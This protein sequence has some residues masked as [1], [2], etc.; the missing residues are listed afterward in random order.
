MSRNYVIPIKLPLGMFLTPDQAAT[1]GRLNISFPLMGILDPERMRE[2]LAQVLGSQGWK[3]LDG[4]WERTSPDLGLWRIDPA[5][6]TLEVDISRRLPQTVSVSPDALSHPPDPEF[7]D[8]TPQDIRPEIRRI[9]EANIAGLEEKTKDDLVAD[10]V[11]ARQALSE[12]LR[13]V[14]RQALQEK[15][16]S[17]GNVVSVSESAQDGTMRIRIEIA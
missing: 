3:E 16:R 10:A 6:T 14:Y 8:P 5:T 15:A 11:R 1:R 9:L 17:L 13:D 2:L 4:K 7:G 12:A